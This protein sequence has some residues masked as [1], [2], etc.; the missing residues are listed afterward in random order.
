MTHLLTTL[1]IVMLLPILAKAPLVMMLI[2]Q[3]GGYDNNNPRAQQRNLKG[4]GER[5][6]AAHYNSFEALIMFASAVLITGLSGDIDQG[7]IALAYTF[8]IARVAYLFC[9][10]YDKATLRSWVWLVGVIALFVMAARA[11][12]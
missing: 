12:W 1:F 6:T 5:A 8:V 9:Y 2:K 11:I 7:S 4:F 10:W 3:K